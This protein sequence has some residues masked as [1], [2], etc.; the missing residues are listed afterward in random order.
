MTGLNFQDTSSE[1]QALLA[2]V[3]EKPTDPM[4][5]LDLAQAYMFSQQIE[6]GLPHLRLASIL[7]KNHWKTRFLQA[8]VMAETG[9]DQEALLIWRELAQDPDA[10]CMVL[11]ALAGQEEYHGDRALAAPLLD[12]AAQ[13]DPGNP[14]FPTLAGLARMKADADPVGLKLVEEGYAAG[15][16]HRFALSKE[17]Q[18]Y[19]FYCA[20]NPTISGE[21]L[22]TITTEWADRH[23]N[24]I[25]PAAR[26]AKPREGRKL[27]VGIVTADLTNH[28]IGSYMLPLVS[29]PVWQDTEL[30]F[31]Y[32]VIKSDEQTE[33]FKATG[34]PIHLLND[35]D[36]LALPVATGLDLD[37]AID[38]SSHTGGNR[39]MLM[40]HRLAAAQL[41]WLGYPSTTGLKAM[42]FKLI[43]PMLEPPDR[44]RLWNAEEPLD[45]GGFYWGYPVPPEKIMEP[46]RRAERPVMVSL[47]FHRKLVPEV[48]AAW[49]EILRRVPGAE[50]RLLDG[51]GTER[52][53]SH[54]AAEGI[55]AARVTFLPRTFR[56]PYMEYYLDARLNLDPWPYNGHTTSLD[57]V[58]MG[59]PVLTYAYDSA[60]GRAGTSLNVRLGLP[61]LVAKTVDDYIA[62]AVQLLTGPD[63]LP[64]PAELRQRL[65]S[66]SNPAI[67]ARNLHRCCHEAFDIVLAR[68]ASAT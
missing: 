29:D 49:A 19:L 50:L 21:R 1:L 66:F 28:V 44:Q 39:L 22:C 7:A 10:D 53:R 34:I 27:R 52:I 45:F 47:N 26:I 12:R 23:P 48:I 30:V 31:L 64:A 41:T 60:V 36:D 8:F 14:M 24:R 20:H 54:F 5:R 16:M 68:Q 63:L 25:T 40:A 56:K 59:V 3:A 42:D 55:D 17:F 9:K 51:A 13:R 18:N 35:K 33:R 61:E 62:R 43:D 65:L 6:A 32:T 38:L 46:V 37:V 15:A 11:A 58:Y 2:R 4:A 57:A 67:A